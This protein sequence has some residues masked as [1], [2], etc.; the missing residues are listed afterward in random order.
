MRIGDTFLGLTATG[1]HAVGSVLLTVVTAYGVWYAIRAHRR[2]K[3]SQGARWLHEVF[4][5]LYVE[6]TFALARESVEYDYTASVEP[7]IAR[8]IAAGP[9]GS[10]PREDVELVRQ[11]DTLLAY[12]EHVLFLSSEGHVSDRDRRSVCQYWF[13]LLRHPSRSLLRRYVGE[14]GFE[15]VA[16]A[17]DTF[18]HERLEPQVTVGE[19]LRT[20]ATDPPGP[21]G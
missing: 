18:P 13:G 3:D 1:W 17:L 16:R 5:D 10:I 8:R 9:A 19:R 7:V 20:L 12:F 6:S 15:R 2:A 14:R 11:L 21:R 4:R